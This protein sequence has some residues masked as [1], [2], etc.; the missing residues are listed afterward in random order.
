MARE[1]VATGQYGGVVELMYGKRA[2]RCDGVLALTEKLL[3]LGYEASTVDSVVIEDGERS[4]DYVRLC[5]YR[6]AA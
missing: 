2:A 3:A 5:A 6:E 1:L 4:G